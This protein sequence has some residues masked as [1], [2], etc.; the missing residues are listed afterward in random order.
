[1]TNY[2]RQLDRLSA[3]V[4]NWQ[5][6]PDDDAG[7]DDGVLLGMLLRALEPLGDNP[8][9]GGDGRQTPLPVA[10]HVR[11]EDM[12][13]D[14]LDAAILDHAAALLPAATDQEIG[15]ALATAGVRPDAHAHLT[16]RIRTY[17]E[18]RNR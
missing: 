10:R 14:E 6:D 16:R 18:G 9:A 4:R 7:L 8:P 13:D 2:R 1:M 12:T 15:Q 5:A 3:D 11:V 17:T